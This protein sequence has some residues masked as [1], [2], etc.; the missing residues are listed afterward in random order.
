MGLAAN[1]VKF[2]KSGKVVILL[3]GKYAGRKA[4]IVK[5]YDEGTNERPYGH[6]MVAG[7]NRYPLKVTKNMGAKRLAKRSK[8]KPF[9]KVVNYN[10][11]M[12]TRYSFEDPRSLPP[13]PP[14]TRRLRRSRTSS[15][16][17][18]CR[19]AT[20]PARTVGSSRSCASKQRACCHTQLC[21]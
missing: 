2:L 6:C 7:I 5:S 19:T 8:V 18:F 3:Q 21:F 1:M 13:T 15:S 17:S 11:I 12:P 14:P 10:H 4:V 9:I 16:R 20:P